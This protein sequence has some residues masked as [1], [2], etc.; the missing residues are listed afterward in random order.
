[1][2]ALEPEHF[3]DPVPGYRFRFDQNNSEYYTDYY[4]SKIF[5]I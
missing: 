1:M 3:V 2:K 4:E 5:H